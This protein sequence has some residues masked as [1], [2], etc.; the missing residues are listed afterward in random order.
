MVTTT[1]A[2]GEAGIIAKA[3]I[4]KG[5]TTLAVKVERAV[6]TGID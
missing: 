2:T 6:V 5:T 4:G 3:A 1:M